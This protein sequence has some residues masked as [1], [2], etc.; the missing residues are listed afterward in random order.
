MSHNAKDH[1]LQ[2]LIDV[3]N[4][5]LHYFVSG[6]GGYRTHSTVG[7]I[8][9]GG[10]LMTQMAPGGNATLNTGVKVVFAEPTN[11]LMSVRI[12]KD[13]HVTV[14]DKHSQIVHESRF[15]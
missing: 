5:H 13:V 1:S 9:G 15:N 8:L 10:L 12:G 4:D 6:G 14:Y 3:S 11:G 7:L 2:H